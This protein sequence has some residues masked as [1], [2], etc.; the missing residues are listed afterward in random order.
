MAIIIKTIPM[1]AGIYFFALTG[2]TASY[3]NEAFS[4]N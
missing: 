3:L 2:N 1:S 4:P